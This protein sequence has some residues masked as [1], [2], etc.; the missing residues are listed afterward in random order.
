[1]TTSLEGAPSSAREQ[2]GVGWWTGDPRDIRE[3]G[4]SVLAAIAAVRSPAFIVQLPNG[5]HGVTL[6]G[7]IQP[8]RGAGLR[9]LGLVPP[10]YPEWLGGRRF[11]DAHRTRFAYVTG[12]M[13]HAIAGPRMVIAAARA[14]LL[15]FLGTAGVPVERV[16]QM[17]G[18]IRS[19]LDPLGLSW[20]V[21]LL[22]TP[23]DVAHERA[24]TELYVR[25]GVTRVSASAFMEMSPN[26]VRYACRG[27]TRDAAGHI[28]RRHHVFAKISRVEVARPFMHPPSAAML[29]ALV[30]DGA[31][32][33]DEA[34][35]G[36]CVPIAEDITVEADSAGHTDHRPLTVVLP[37]IAALRDELADAGRCEGARR[38]R[39]GAA[40][41]LGTPAAVAAAF[42]LGAD[43]VLTGSINQVAIESGLS[44]AGRAML[45]DA[46]TTDVAM[47]PSADMFE[48]GVNV[49]VLKR[50]T[51]FASR[52]RLLFELYHAHDGLD[53]LPSARRDQIER[54]IFR[55]PLADVWTQTAAYLATHRPGALERA[56]RDPKHRMALVFRW[57]LGLSARW[58]IQGDESR[59]SDYQL[60]C[61]PALG[62]F[63]AWTAGSFLAEPARRSVDQIAWNL[64]EGAAAIAR[65]QQFRTMGVA[66]PAAAFTFAPRP[67]A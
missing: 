1:M 52:A 46:D 15:G 44:D 50:G 37:R 26:V 12:E 16:E 18:E 47:A 3:D 45:Q 10:V 14:G 36:A 58:P 35:L 39:V 25:L 6:D 20:G 48:M 40:G 2:H 54:D 29:D 28:V 7:R 5:A 66:V 63:N 41:G 57:Y 21:N 30:R 11:Q 65:A 56:A 9:A 24:L 42:A 19:A 38:I 33:A 27:L 53:D 23:A 64:L 67:L 55:M 49:Q 43:Y 62:A 34:A 13:A 59:R 32:T 17:I 51:L 22:S 61:G 4:P 31:L 60:W 8:D